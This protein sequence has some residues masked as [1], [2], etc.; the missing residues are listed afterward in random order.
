[1][2]TVMAAIPNAEI[3][4]LSLSRLVLSQLMRLVI[5]QVDSGLPRRPLGTLTY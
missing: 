2:V 4:A 3:K 5:V 1:M